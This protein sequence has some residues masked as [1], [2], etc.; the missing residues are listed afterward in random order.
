[1]RPPGA[2]G[3]CASGRLL[4]VRG[5]S[6]VLCLAAL[7]S[8]VG[9]QIHSLAVVHVR[10]LAHGELEHVEQAAA[11]ADSSGETSV[12]QGAPTAPAGHEHCALAAALGRALSQRPTAVVV[13]LQA[14]PELRKQPPATTEP[15]PLRPR[16]A[17]LLAPKT[18]PPCG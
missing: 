5:L 8:M 13:G 12:E 9:G 18:S 1:M 4:S 10:C 16:A 2:R 15:R 3:L 6:A 14:P 17:V 11:E 7:A